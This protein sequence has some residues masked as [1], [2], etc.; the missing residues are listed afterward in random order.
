MDIK[1]GTVVYSLAGHD[2][3]DF[4]VVMDFDDKYAKVC[5]GKYRPIERL[6]SKKLIHLKF[7]N[8]VL[9]EDKLR[10]NKS[11]RD[12]LRPFKEASNKC[13]NT[14]NLQ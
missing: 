14:K 1:K 4:Q 10:T 5:D 11:V 2:K 6:K 8:T 13:D 9:S 7:T 3:G 12:A